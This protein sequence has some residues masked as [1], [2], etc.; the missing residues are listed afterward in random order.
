MKK[1]K[2]ITEWIG[3]NIIERQ[4]FGFYVE[5]LPETDGMWYSKS[6]DEK[7]AILIQQLYDKSN[8]NPLEDGV[9]EGKNMQA[10]RVKI[11]N[12]HKRAGQEK[13]I[14]FLGRQRPEVYKKLLE[15]YCKYE[16]L[17]QQEKSPQLKMSLDS[18]PATKE[19]IDKINSRINGMATEAKEMKFILSDIRTNTHVTA[20]ES[21]KIKKMFCS[22]VAFL[23]LIG[24]YNPEKADKNNETQI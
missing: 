5:T 6:H 2:N 10:Y 8:K 11:N 7:V 13:D 20:T 12:D 24:R 22:V 17:H 9:I 15:D 16:T 3:K 23:K 21:E 18:P 14:M 1:N 4:V 19:D